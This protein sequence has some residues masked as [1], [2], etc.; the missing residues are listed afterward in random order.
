MHFMND[1]GKVAC[2]L[3]ISLPFAFPHNEAI[4][5]NCCFSCCVGD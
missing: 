3:H 4:R 5:I 1:L 2:L